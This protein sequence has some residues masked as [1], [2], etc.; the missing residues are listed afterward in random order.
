MSAT[1]GLL[2]VCGLRAGLH[3]SVLAETEAGDK[4]ETC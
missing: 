3:L 1:S 4:L 2:Y